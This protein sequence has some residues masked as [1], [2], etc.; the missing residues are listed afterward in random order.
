VSKIVI[1]EGPISEIEKLEAVRRFAREQGLSPIIALVKNAPS[2][3]PVV[4]APG[5][6]DQFR[7]SLAPMRIPSLLQNIRWGYPLIVNR[8]RRGEKQPQFLRFVDGWIFFWIQY[9]GEDEGPLYTVACITP[10][11]L[12][13]W[14][15]QQKERLGKRQVQTTMLSSALQMLVNEHPP[16]LVIVEEDIERFTRV[17][18]HM[19]WDGTQPNIEGAQNHVV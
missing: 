5:P 16:D 9:Q 19:G 1:I 11:N 3:V 13:A 6:N 18:Y 10:E 2:G 15:N 7:I 12:F 14:Y 17:I 4:T 8:H